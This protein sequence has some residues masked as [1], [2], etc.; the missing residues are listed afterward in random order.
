M[1]L[2]VLAKREDGDGF[3]NRYYLPVLSGDGWVRALRT[4]CKTP[5]RAVDWGQRVR[6]RLMLIYDAQTRVKEPTA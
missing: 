3:L 1:Y 5:R 2:D 6:T 4:K